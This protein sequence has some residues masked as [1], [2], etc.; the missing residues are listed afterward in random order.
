MK[1]QN[2]IVQAAAAAEHNS[3]KPVRKRAV[4]NDATPE[5]LQEVCRDNPD[6]ILVFRDELAGWLAEMEQQSRQGERALYLELWNGDNT[7]AV[8]RIMR[9][10]IFAPAICCSLLGGIQP[11][12]LARYMRTSQLDRDGLIQ[13]LQLL[14]QPDITESYVYTDRAPDAAAQKTFDL[15]CWAMKDISAETP[16]VAR[17]S[18]DAQ[19]LFVEWFVALEERLRTL[20]DSVIAEHVSK[21][22]SL[23]PSLALL[24]DLADFGGADGFEGFEVLRGGTYTV[25]AQ[26]TQRAIDWCAYLEEHAKRIYSVVGTAAQNAAELLGDKIRARKVG[27]ENGFFCSRDVYKNDWKGLDSPARAQ[28]AI[29]G[30]IKAHWIRDAS[31]PSGKQGGRPSQTYQINPLVW[32]MT[33]V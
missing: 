20:G 12:T 11:R 14:I 28:L 31:Q 15:I 18:P 33:G 27:D 8:D 4:V 21:Y 17:F 32:E 7:Y 10:T 16:I 26:N 29:K 5:K 1:K 6:G 13:R 23:M 9:G 25:S 19:Q 2:K 30:L 3:D 22:R 24:F